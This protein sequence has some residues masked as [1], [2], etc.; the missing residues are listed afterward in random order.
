M[1][2]AEDKGA[3]CAGQQKHV[4]W[5]LLS[6]ACRKK[7]ASLYFLWAHGYSLAPLRASAGAALAPG[8]SC[9]LD[10]E[11]DWMRH[12]IEAGSSQKCLLILGS[13]IGHHGREQCAYR[14]VQKSPPERE[15][16][17]DRPAKTRG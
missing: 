6:K 17:G 16:I 8:R 7:C 3:P 4:R 2:L 15:L 11:S 12:A 10:T 9:G 13:S 1:T 5:L 14:L